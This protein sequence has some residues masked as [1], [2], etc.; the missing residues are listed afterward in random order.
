MAFLPVSPVQ[1]SLGN[2]MATPVPSLPPSLSPLSLSLGLVGFSRVP[3]L[4]GCSGASIV[5]GALPIAPGRPVP[6]PP[7]PIPRSA[8]ARLQ[9][10]PLEATESVPAPRLTA[11]WGEVV[12]CIVWGSALL[13]VTIQSTV[14][15]E[16]AV[17]SPMDSVQDPGWGGDRGRL[18]TGSSPAGV[19]WRLPGSRSAGLPS[20]CCVI[21]GRCFDLSGLH[22]PHL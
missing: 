9:E 20:T 15:P 4:R 6:P 8:P 10:A 21:L 2:I 11:L 1:M 12:G 16:V 7:A 3:P 17:I 5:P 14:F 19:G 18:G 22:F 13:W